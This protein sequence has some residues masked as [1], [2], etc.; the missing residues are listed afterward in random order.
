MIFRSYSTCAT[1]RSWASKLNSKTHMTLRCSWSN[2]ITK[3]KC[4]LLRRR[5]NRWKKSWVRRGTVFLQ[6]KK[7]FTLWLTTW[8][9]SSKIS[10]M[11]N[12]QEQWRLRSLIW[13]IAKTTVKISFKLLRC[14]R[15]CDLRKR[16]QVYRWR[17]EQMNIGGKLCKYNKSDKKTHGEQKFTLATKFIIF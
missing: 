8:F 2:K 4:K 16:I 17:S 5:L 6:R 7:C 12:L 11:D 1:K 9:L 13:R 15:A 10:I 14:N 3:S